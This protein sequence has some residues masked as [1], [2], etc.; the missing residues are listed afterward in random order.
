MSN[1]LCNLLEAAEFLE[2][3]VSSSKVSIANKAKGVNGKDHETSKV[4]E[5]SCLFL[6]FFNYYTY[7]KNTCLHYILSF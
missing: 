1:G 3:S 2:S 5:S 6:H 4:V 7:I